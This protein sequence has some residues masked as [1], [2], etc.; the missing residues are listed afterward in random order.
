MKPNIQIEVLFLV[1]VF[2]FVFRFYPP[3][4]LRRTTP[5]C[6][7]RQGEAF[8]FCRDNT[9]GRGWHV[10]RST[11]TVGA[12]DSASCDFSNFAINLRGCLK[13]KCEL[14]GGGFSGRIRLSGR[15]IAGYAT[16]ARPDS[17]ENPADNANYPYCLSL[18]V[19][20]FNSV[21]IARSRNRKCILPFVSVA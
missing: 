19:T 21:I 8:Q 15:S 7:P 2:D 17:D 3:S 9:Q 16:E 11:L 13:N 4:H 14:W 5:D 6:C 1:W 12:W 20:L 10:H 18:C